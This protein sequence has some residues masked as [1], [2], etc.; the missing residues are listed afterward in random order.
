MAPPIDR[1]IF[2]VGDIKSATTSVQVTLAADRQPR[3]ASGG[4]VFY[5]AKGLNHNYLEQ[6]LRERNGPHTPPMAWLRQR[7]IAAAPVE[8]CVI[9]G[10]RLSVIAPAKLKASIEESFGDLA[11]EIT[12]LHYIRP[13]VDRLLSAYAERVKIGAETRSLTDF[14]RE[15]TAS[16]RFYQHQ[17]LSRWRKVFGKAYILRAILPARLERGDPVVDFFHT[18]S[19]SVPAD[20]Q[21][22]TPSNESLSAAGLAQ[23][24]RMQAEL[25]DMPAALRHALGYEFAWLYGQQPDAAPSGRIGFDAAMAAELRAAY[26]ADARALDADL[27]SGEDLFVPALETSIQRALGGEA[28]PLSLPADPAGDRIARQLVTMAR[29]APDPLALARKIRDARYDRYIQAARS[30]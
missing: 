13:H 10:E 4:K 30:C 25:K 23:V 14:L 12:V 1:L 16:Q 20:W 7:M 8:T 3:T 28:R 17:R 22:P 15:E 21:P 5:P 19:G 11:R 24:A 9:S 27:F 18:V 2:H 26:G 6:P 29:A